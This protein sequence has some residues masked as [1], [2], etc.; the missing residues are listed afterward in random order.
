V[1]L[2]LEG[3]RCSDPITATP[4]LGSEEVWEFI[5]STPDYHPMHIHLVSFTI[6]GFTPFDVDLYLAEGDLVYTGKTVPPEA[7]EAGPRDVVK[8]P[9]R[10][11]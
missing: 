9:G 8:V 11:V 4:T 5:N 6:E 7:H 10:R 1:L 2:L 3:K